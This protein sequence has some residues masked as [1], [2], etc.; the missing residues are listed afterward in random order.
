MAI[1]L[2]I[3]GFDTTT[4]INC[5]VSFFKLSYVLLVILSNQ[6]CCYVLKVWMTFEV[7]SVS[8]YVAHATTPNSSI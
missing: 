1:I 5:Q 6:L 4:P 3:V 8:F 7:V 2:N